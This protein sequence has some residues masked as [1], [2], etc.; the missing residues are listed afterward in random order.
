LCFNTLNLLTIKNFKVLSSKNFVSNHILIIALFILLTGIFTY[1]SFLEFDSILGEPDDPEGYINHFWWYN[2]NI[3][4]PSEPLD[5]SWIFFHSYQYYPIGAPNSSGG[6]FNIL[7][8]ILVHPFTGN[9]IHT[10]NIIV[11]LSFIFS[12]YGMFLLTKH[13]TKN[14]YASIVA[15]IIFSFGIYHLW[16]GERHVELLPL[17]FIPLS[18]L[19]LI[20][21]VESNKI[22]DPI[23][24]GIFLALGLI[25]SVYLGFFHLLFFIPLILYFILTKR[26][27]QILFRIGILLIIFTSLAIPFVYGHY[28]ANVGNERISMPLSSFNKG[29]ADVANFVLPPPSQSLTKIVDYPFETSFGKSGEGWTFLGFTTIFLAFI[30]LFKTNKKEK[31]IWII[32]GSFLAIISLGPFLKIYGIDTGIQL[33]YYFLY[34]LPYFDLFRAIGRGAVFV[35][36]CVAILAAYGI[37][38]IYKIHL[39]TKRKK[40]L[41]VAIIGIFVIIESLTIPLPTYNIPESQI[42]NQIASDPRNVVVLQAPL[43]KFLLPI[44]TGTLFS[45]Y[46]YYQSI[47]E[48]PII[49]G[50][51]SRPPSETANYVRTY[52]LNQF[53]GDQPSNDI[54]EQDLKEVGIS[55]FDY[56][57]IGYVVIYTDLSRTFNKYESPYVSKIWLPQTKATLSDI[58]SKPPDF[59]DDRL[60]SY[61]VPEP[62]S[63]SPFIVLGDGWSGLKKDYVRKI[64]EYSEIKIINPSSETTEVT[65]DIRFKPTERREITLLFNGNKIS[66]FS[67]DKNSPNIVT[68]PLRL[69]PNENHLSVLQSKTFSAEPTSGAIQSVN[70]EDLGKN[71]VLKVS[72][73]SINIH[74]D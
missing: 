59:S 4:N 11:Y 27:L 38:E 18:V 34:E 68:P 57:D 28:L 58:F 13:L 37:N 44:V 67:V 29:G 3:K 40:L 36:F 7:L 60:F 6:T 51:Q 24:G 63:N 47:H 22:K 12:A 9:F 21:T 8:S 23:I 61:K 62:N 20:K 30:A 31:M 53:I 74:S 73:I 17:Q 19:F 65:L 66:N 5:F 39:I 50:H 41:I 46:I 35:T 1:P 48:K 69:N 2:Y 56:F 55:L 64:G 43:G 52:F 72:K 71:L 45:D 15:G 10:Y 16:H 70:T 42:Y 14:Y 32:S 26:N 33:P 49:S 54:V 25:S